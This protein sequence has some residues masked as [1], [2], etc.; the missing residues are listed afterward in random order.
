MKDS[1][2]I[3]IEKVTNTFKKE[4]A[5]KNT[6]QGKKEIKQTCLTKNSPTNLLSFVVTLKTL[7][8]NI[9]GRSM[10]YSE[11]GGR[12]TITIKYKSYSLVTKPN[13]ERK[14]VLRP[15]FLL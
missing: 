8:S 15:L 11:S 9:H 6:S 13:D 4:G 12:R 1:P 14:M 10:E 3:S 7:S 2:Q 5:L